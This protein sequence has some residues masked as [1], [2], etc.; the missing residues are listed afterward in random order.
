MLIV[1]E[2]V[3]SEV[4]AMKN[5]RF[6][7]AALLYVILFLAFLPSFGL[8]ESVQMAILTDT[9]KMSDESIAEVDDNLSVSASA[10]KASGT[11][12]DN[13]TWTL[14]DE[15][16]LTITGSGEMKYSNP[17]WSRYR[18]SI[19]A[20]YVCEG[21]TYIGAGAFQQCSNLTSVIIPESAVNFGSAVFSLSNKLKTAGPLGS[22][23][24]IEF[25]WKEAIPAHPFEGADGLTSVIIPKSVTKIGDYAF[26]GSGLTTVTILGSIESYGN[27]AFNYCNSLTDVYYDGYEAAMNYYRNWGGGSGNEPLFNATWHFSKIPDEG[28]DLCGDDV[29]YQFDNAAR[30]LSIKGSGPMWSVGIYNENVWPWGDYRSRIV[31]VDIEDGVTS[32]GRLAFKNCDKLWQV[33]IPQSMIQIASDAFYGCS[34]LS[35]LSL[36]NTITEIG[37]SVFYGCSNLKDINIPNGLKVI[38]I[39]TFYGCSNLSSLIIPQSVRSIGG[40]AFY[41][42]SNLSSLT[43]PQG[44]S[45]I[46]GETFYGCCS[47]SHLIIPD[48]ITTIQKSAFTNC[49]NLSR[50]VFL[51]GPPDIDNSS[52]TNV[53]ADAYYPDN[54]CWLEVDRQNYGGNITWH[55]NSDFHDLFLPTELTIIESEAFTNLLNIDRIHIPTSVT[56]ISHDAFDADIIIVAVAQS[57]A[58][59][60][61]QQNGFEYIIEN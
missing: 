45:S 2:I 11:C 57:Y 13:L 23:C 61:A 25:G 42:C 34:Y 41:G 54:G 24:N 18:N 1:L 17:P 37:R 59:T 29:L 38:D 26:Y 30:K 39:Q 53:T 12:G 16:T 31:Y 50:I 48:S 52:F 60:W 4:I 21:V 9:G 35:E 55:T 10:I 56:S 5:N 3:D 20:V 14:D 44:V 7:L 46:A 28:W 40:Q 27:W 6:V 32:I 22:G 43:I 58:I 36:P 15:G 19:Q 33:N 51:G 47:L 8:A 49:N